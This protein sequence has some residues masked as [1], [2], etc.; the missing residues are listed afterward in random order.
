MNPQL[1]MLQGAL[2]NVRSRRYSNTLDPTAETEA[3]DQ[4][5]A[6]KQVPAIPPDPEDSTPTS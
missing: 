1:R 4:S 5:S 2:R 3:T 6:D